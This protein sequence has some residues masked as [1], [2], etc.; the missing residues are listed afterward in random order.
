MPIMRLVW[1]LGCILCA[2]LFA[3]EL[4]INGYSK[5]VVPRSQGVWFNENAA[6]REALRNAGFEVHRSVDEI[7]RE[8]RS[9]ALWMTAR[10][11]DLAFTYSILVFDV[12]TNIAIAACKLDARNVRGV[13]VPRRAYGG[14]D[15][16][17]R[18]AIYGIIDGLGYQGFNESAHETNLRVFNLA[19]SATQQ[20]APPTASA[21]PNGPRL[22]CGAAPPPAAT[23]ERPTRRSRRRSQD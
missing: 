6:L 13:Q 4:D 2:P 19:R 17:G 20:S 12:A 18:T 9:T 16:I 5:V 3:Q 15:A 1:L 11:V 22:S 14:A 8:A 23:E 10:L 7:P 21:S